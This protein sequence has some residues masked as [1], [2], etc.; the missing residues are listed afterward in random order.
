MKKKK[1]VQLIHGFNMGGAETLVKEY[2]LKL[3]REKYDVA[4]LC[5]F[6]YH[7]PYEKILEDAGVKIT[8]IDD[9]NEAF[10]RDGKSRLKRALMIV[11]RYLF[12]RSYIRKEA[13]DILHTHLALNSYVL[14]ASPKKGTKLLHTVHNEPTVL[15]NQSRAR[16]IDYA[17]VCRLVKKYQMQFITLHESMRK[18]VNEMFGVSNSVVLNNGID[19]SRFAHALPKE[20]VR[21]NIGIPEDA[22][23]LGHIGRFDVQKNH[24]FLIE[25]F[26]KIYEK[27]ENAFLLLIG[28]GKLQPEIEKQLKDYGLEHRSMI[29]SHRTDIPDLLNA[30]DKFVF[31]SVFEGLG[32]VL[33]E[34]Q[35]AGLECIA[36]DTVPKAA[37]VSNLVKQLS[38]ELSAEEWADEVMKFQVASPEYQGIE[39]WDMSCVIQKLEE[40]YDC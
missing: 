30:M 8:Y 21:R 1:V 38:L 13:P 19:F 39:E 35:R 27:N 18:E 28:N 10:T 31:P 5:F 7:T 3:N 6:R 32:I 36:S 2:C 4:A 29:L 15:W 37:V 14:F 22:F 33:I 24:K 40:L 11:H 9:Y 17:S 25:V 34:A 26:A 12:I 23:V 20:A 16:R